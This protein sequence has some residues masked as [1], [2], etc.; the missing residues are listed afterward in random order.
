MNCNNPAFLEFCRQTIAYTCCCEDLKGNGFSPFWPLSYI[1]DDTSLLLQL[2]ELREDLV[3]KR[4]VKFYPQGSCMYPCIRP[5]DKLHIEFKKIEDIKTGDIAV[6]RRANLLFSHRVIDRGI[7]ESRDYIITRPDTAQYGNDGPSFDKDIVGIISKI[8]RRGRRIGTER[9][10]YNLLKR[11]FLSLSLK[12][13]YFKQY[14]FKG[15]VFVIIHLQQLKAYKGIARLLNLGLNKKISF[16]ILCPLNYKVDSRFYRLASEEELRENAVPKWRLGLKVNSK[17]AATLSF[18]RKPKDCQFS[19]CWLSGIKIR[20]R[21]RSTGIEEELFSYADKLLKKS[22][23]DEI[24]AAL[25]K[26]AYLE[27]VFLKGM[28]FEE[29][30]VCGLRAVMKRR[31]Y[32]KRLSL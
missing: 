22:G 25:A 2:F 31:V 26:P 21:Y 29:I 12:W 5:S 6:Y 14:L 9:R 24:F 30:G 10:E 27:R 1:P 32:V 15:I 13:Y 4:I 23:V 17:T 19:G 28:G 20:L 11:A 3:G 8:E 7:K 18:V 16:S